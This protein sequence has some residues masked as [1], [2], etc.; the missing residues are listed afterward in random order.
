MTRHVRAHVLVFWFLLTLCAGG[1]AAAFADDDDSNENERKTTSFISSV[2]ATV[3]AAAWPTATYKDWSYKS[4]E[5]VSGGGDLV[6]R[7]KGESAF[8]GE[9]WLDLRFEFRNGGLSDVRIHGHN[10]ILVPPF[11][12]TIAAG[13]AIGEVVAQYA[14]EN[15]APSSTY[16]PPGNYSPP[17]SEQLPVARAL[18]VANECQIPISLWMHT[19]GASGQWATDGEWV[20][21]AS[22]ATLLADSRSVNLALSDAN[23]FFYAELRGTDLAWRGEGQFTFGNRT[24]PMRKI[25]LGTSAD[26][27]YELRFNSC[28]AQ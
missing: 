10:A 12:T 23:V 11:E 9:L 8:G 22:H 16:S 20:I 19:R 18:R 15:S 27:A 25:T 17:S 24:L 3:Y 1:G 6:V 28:T 13:K 2:A 14:R 4:F 26:G 21:G 5:R 7:F